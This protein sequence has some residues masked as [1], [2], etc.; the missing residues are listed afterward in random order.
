MAT[1]YPVQNESCPIAP[2]SSNPAY[3]GYGTHGNSGGGAGTAIASGLGGLAAGTFI[4]DMM[5]RNR[6][7]VHN[8]QYAAGGYNISGDSGGYDIVGDSGDADGGFD[9]QGDS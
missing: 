2:P 4:G 9:I 6:A 1:A 8:A 7:E 5:G 3:H